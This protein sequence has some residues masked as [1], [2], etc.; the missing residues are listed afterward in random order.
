MSLTYQPVIQLVD[1]NGVPRAFALM[2]ITQTGTTTPVEVYSDA[3]QTEPL[4][5][6]IAA[7]DEGIFPA[8]YYDP[9]SL[10]RMRIIAADGDF[11]DPLIDI[12][13]FNIVLEVTADMI[14]DG[15]IEEKLGY[16]P[17]DPANAVFTAPAR[18]VMDP[19]NPPLNAYD[20][21]YMGSPRNIKDI[22]YNIVVG[23]SG[24]LLMHDDVSTVTWIIQP[25]AADPVYG[26]PI[27]HGFWVYNDNTGVVT[28]ARGAGVEL[29]KAGESTSQ[30]LA[31]N[32]WQMAY[33]KQVDT[34]KWTAFGGIDDSGSS[35][36]KFVSSL[37]EVAD[38]VVQAH[39]LSG[40]PDWVTL[41]LYCN[42]DELGYTAGER[43]QLV[44]SL[45][46]TNHGVSVQ[47]TAHDISIHKST[48]SIQVISAGT[49]TDITESFWNFEIR[50]GIFP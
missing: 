4:S 37:I 3:A 2:S 5:Q 32:Q 11:G 45:N 17:V 24:C 6:P 31:L 10:Y 21:G 12:D 38:A 47:A 27:G 15:A 46:S 8:I 19:A 22:N 49:V 35:P 28:I 42:T 18:Y 40:V 16:T 34:D 23:D 20:L 29:R 39:G 9:G 44:A 26:F 50:C 36:S 33:I 48:G 41:Y 14:A 13:P 25:N 43:V 1:E 30:D 7:D